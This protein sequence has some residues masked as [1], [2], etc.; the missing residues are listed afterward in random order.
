MSFRLTDEQ[1]AQLETLSPGY[2]YYADP[3]QWCLLMLDRAMTLGLQNQL[4]KLWILDIGSAVPYFARV[5]KGFGHHVLSLDIDGFD[6]VKAA[7][8]LECEFW[9]HKIQPSCWLPEFPHK[10]DL[11]TMWGVNLRNEECTEENVDYRD[12]ANLLL[13]HIVPK[14]RLVIS[15]NYG[16]LDD[17]WKD[18]GW[19]REKLSTGS[20]KIHAATITIEAY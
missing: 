17:A 7:E 15:M 4:H 5:A 9:V 20:I 1:V 19:W 11:I 10:F 13:Q 18:S 3:R 6:Y 2:K 16:W 14:G 8:I 12:F